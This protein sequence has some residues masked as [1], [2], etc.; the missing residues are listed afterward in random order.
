MKSIKC[1]CCGAN[2]RANI[3]KHNYVCPYCGTSY[4]QEEKPDDN[5]SQTETAPLEPKIETVEYKP[6]KVVDTSDRPVI[7]P[8]IMI[9][10]LIFYVWPGIL[11][12]MYKA[13][14]QSKW[15]K[16]HNDEK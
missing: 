10:G 8:V 2:I 4:Y 14:Q 12:I 9:I 11:Y 6:K 16:E 15:D 13:Y 7:N 1:T 3:K 5:Q